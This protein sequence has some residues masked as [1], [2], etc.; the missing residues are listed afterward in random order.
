M[1]TDLGTVQYL[2]YPC[3]GLA[4]TPQ[5]AMASVE[6]RPNIDPSFVVLLL[7]DVPLGC[8][9]HAS[10]LGQL[11]LSLKRFPQKPR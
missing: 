6:I 10:Q 11:C 7:D 2:S 1:T 8:S 4:L 9:S 3:L 5:C